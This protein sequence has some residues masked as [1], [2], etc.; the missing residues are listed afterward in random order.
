M[1]TIRLRQL[2]PV[3]AF[4]FC[5]AAT[6][7]E[8]SVPTET[9]PAMPASAPAVSPSDAPAVEEPYVGE[10]LELTAE[11]RAERSL[12]TIQIALD[13]T[14]SNSVKDEELIVCVKQ[15]PTGS[16]RPVIN[17]AT[18]R[19]WRKIRE[20]SLGGFTGSGGGGSAKKDDKVFT[21][22]VEDYA[23]LEKRFGKLPQEMKEKT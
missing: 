19:F 14:R 20:N 10:P 18:N 6:A 17:C 15:M 23:K 13:R 2:L 4:A 12:R 22:S 11:Q 3:L 5:G 1:T 16:H 8:L 7:A 9:D 21:M